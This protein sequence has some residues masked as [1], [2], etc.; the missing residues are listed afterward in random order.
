MNYLFVVNGRF[1]TQKLTGVH[2]YAYE[3]CC[4]LKEIGCPFI[5]IAPPN[6]LSDYNCPFDIERC[7]KYSSHFWEQ[8]ELPL[9]LK[10]RYK[11]KLLINFM[12]LGSVFYGRT[13]TTI[14]DLSYLENPLWFSKSYYLL[15]KFLTPISAKRS[16]KILTVSYFSKKE[17]VKNL[18]IN[19][20]KIEVIY[21][22]VTTNVVASN[23]KSK[24]KEKY[25]ISVSSFDPRK[26]FKRLIEAFNLLKSYEYKLCIIGKEN[27]VF[28]SV[29][30]DELDKKNIL[31][32]G[33][34]TD[35]ELAQYYH[36]AILSVYPSLYEG[37]G[38]PN[39]EAMANNCPV[40]TS[41]IPP[42]REVCGDA[43]VYFDPNDINDIS[44]KIS[45][46]INNKKLQDEMILKGKLR[47]SEFSWKLSAEKLL[48]I[49]NNTLS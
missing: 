11:G 15:Y 24:L 20:E 1:L 32:T 45:F 17:I 16:L 6:I 30:F 41:D 10:K 43:A 5:V 46:V 42:H 23:D 37:F 34:V 48:H 36:N 31:F 14:H 12:G 13:I 29:D 44:E 26:N 18:K 49:I 28:N 40:V 35:E 33:Y 9:Y 7:G 19:P 8:V 27:R 25:I 47:F 21:N 22:A 3:M 38:I 4:A 39:L 2:R